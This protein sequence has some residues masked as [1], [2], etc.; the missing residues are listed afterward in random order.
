MATKGKTQCT[1]HQL[2]GAME[3]PLRLLP[4]ALALHLW[5][6]YCCGAL[7][8]VFFCD[9]LSH[10]SVFPSASV[11]LLFSISSLYSIYLSLILYSFTSCSFSYFPFSFFLSHLSVAPP[12]S[13]S[14]FLSLL[15]PPSRSLIPRHKPAGSPCPH[16]LPVPSGPL[17]PCCQSPPMCLCAT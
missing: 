4:F 8:S 5:L 6:Y 12:L 2:Q 10:L 13:I 1:C 7:N 3:A 17:H 15:L 16:R 14:P 9:H 11:S